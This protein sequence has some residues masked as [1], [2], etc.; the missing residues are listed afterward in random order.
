MDNVK[1]WTSLPP[2]LETVKRRK[3]AWFGY[4]THYD[5]TILEGTLER[6]KRLDRQR[7]C[8]MDNVKEWMSLPPLLETVKRGKLAWFEYVTHHDK[9]ILEGTLE[10]V[11]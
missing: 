5:K 8:W 2:L 1:E 10:R 11:S 6:R 3:L 4:V 7:K 9:T